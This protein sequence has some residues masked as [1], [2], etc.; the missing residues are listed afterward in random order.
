MKS[1]GVSIGSSGRSS[2]G[3]DDDD[4]ASKSV[5]ASHQ[6]RE[7][8]IERRKFEVR[9]KVESQLTRAQQQAKRLTQVWEEKEYKEA[10]EAFQE[11][12]KEKAQLT[13]ALVEL[14]NQSEN[15][16]MKKLEELTKILNS[17]K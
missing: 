11:K 3:D 13:T 17:T 7:E 8:E 4:E 10:L 12:S 2:A 15:M 16:R 6:A 14:V 5:L 9:A 1:L